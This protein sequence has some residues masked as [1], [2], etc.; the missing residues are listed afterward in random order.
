MSQRSATPTSRVPQARLVRTADTPLPGETIA[1]ERAAAI[2][3]AYVG[4]FFDLQ[5]KGIPRPLLDGPS[6][7]YPE[8]T[9]Q[10]P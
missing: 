6:R 5:L 10:H 2:T 9:F 8:V 7:A 4:D 1:A 3:R